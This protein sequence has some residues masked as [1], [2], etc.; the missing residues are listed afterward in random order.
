MPMA[1]STPD[2]R[3]GHV[4]A[5]G[6]WM[7]LASPRTAGAVGVVALVAPFAAIPLA[8]LIDRS[9][10][11]GP[12]VVGLFLVFGVVFAAVGVVVARREPRSP[13][14]WLLLGASLAMT[15][16]NA[17][18]EYAYLDYTVHHGRLPL[19]AIGILLSQAWV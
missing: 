6:R 5:P 7:R 8:I 2:G 11:S 4:A 17:G 12:S 14:G 13:I 15:V 1:T 3:D 16:G 18:P 9:T 19:G 10:L